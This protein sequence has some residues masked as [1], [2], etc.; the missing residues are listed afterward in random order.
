MNVQCEQ[1]SDDND[2][3]VPPSTREEN[4]IDNDEDEQDRTED[5]MMSDGEDIH[6]HDFDSAGCGQDIHKHDFD[7]AGCG[8]D[9]TKLNRS[10]EMTNSYS[11]IQTDTLDPNNAEVSSTG[12]GDTK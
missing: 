11:D 9:I 2:D 5:E 7:S 10:Q 3:C 6:K 1:C 12:H 8:Q 4:H